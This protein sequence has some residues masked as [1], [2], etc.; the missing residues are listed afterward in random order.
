MIVL[1]NIA[2]ST[3]MRR[4][5]YPILILS[6][7]CFVSSCKKTE[8]VSKP[9]I[10]ILCESGYICENAILGPGEDV[11]L[12]F[13]YSANGAPVTCFSQRL[14]SESST[15]VVDSGIYAENGT[16]IV[17]ISKSLVLLEKWEFFV[18]DR[19]GNNSDTIK[20]ELHLDTAA[21]FGQITRIGSATLGAQ[22]STTAGSFFGISSATVYDAQQAFQNQTQIN[23]VYYYDFITSDANT[24][25]SP[26]ANIDTS[27]FSGQY[28]LPNWT[29]LNTTRFVQT[30]VAEND[31]LSATHDSIIL[32]NG[33][34]FASGKR[35]AKNLTAGDVYAFDNEVNTGLFLV[36]QVSGT[37]DGSITIELIYR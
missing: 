13:S 23:L 7:V 33:F 10:Q 3:D 16:F 30:S 14:F 19:N 21:Q 20:I 32:A 25:A 22:T 17:R 15:T 28:N 37:G 18:R 34:V 27:V 2:S 24:I 31:F 9:E 8:D 4:L 26:G 5:A 1:R 12:K 35:K 29:T 11:E 36:R 6:F